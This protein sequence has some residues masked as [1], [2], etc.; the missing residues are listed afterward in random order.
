M[1]IVVKVLPN[2]ENRQKILS[3]YHK[4]SREVSIRGCVLEYVV[5]DHENVKFDLTI[6][7]T[8]LCLSK[9]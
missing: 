8:K 4:T 6:L 2:N 1:K 3:M 9:A 5:S 7:G